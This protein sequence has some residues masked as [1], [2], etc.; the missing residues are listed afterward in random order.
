MP[1]T[2]P[3]YTTESHNIYILFESIRNIQCFEQCSQCCYLTMLDYL[4]DFLLI[5][6]CISRALLLLRFNHLKLA[7]IKS[8]ICQNDYSY[9]YS[10]NHGLKK[11][12]HYGNT[13]IYANQIYSKEQSILLRA[14]AANGL[15]TRS[16][17]LECI[18]IFHQFIQSIEFRS[19]LLLLFFTNFW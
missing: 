1:R 11:C 9:L 16:V 12:Q 13:F 14:I 18:Q 15:K 10:S 6:V 17:F 4:H 2:Q 3:K 8:F 19:P 5:F 7:T